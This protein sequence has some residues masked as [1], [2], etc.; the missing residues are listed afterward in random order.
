MRLFLMGF[1]GCTLS[2]LLCWALC[3]VAARAERKAAQLFRDAACDAIGKADP[4]QATQQRQ[5]GIV[6]RGRDDGRP[7]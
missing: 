5:F 1:V 3:V 2:A 7:W 4:P 6:L